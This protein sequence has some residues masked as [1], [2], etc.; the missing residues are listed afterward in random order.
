[1]ANVLEAWGLQ[2]VFGLC[3]VVAAAGAVVTVVFIDETVGRSLEQINAPP[4]EV[5]L[6]Q[7][8]S[9]PTHVIGSDDDEDDDRL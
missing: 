6:Q 7:F 9:L 5:D 1:M 2:V 8:S 4:S 3:G